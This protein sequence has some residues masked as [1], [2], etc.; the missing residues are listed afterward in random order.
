MKNNIVILGV[1]I[2]AAVVK[3]RLQPTAATAASTI[4][5]VSSCSVTAA[6]PFGALGARPG[7]TKLYFFVEG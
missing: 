6:Q 1:S 4:S 2:H 7:Q 5:A 3:A